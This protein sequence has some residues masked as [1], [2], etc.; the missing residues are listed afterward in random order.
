MKRET[1]A[2]LLYSPV[3]SRDPG[4]GAVGAGLCGW[5]CGVGTFS[6]KEEGRKE[7]ARAVR[8]R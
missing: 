5:G 3:A 8:V 1:T 7:K 6:G 2:A 4:F